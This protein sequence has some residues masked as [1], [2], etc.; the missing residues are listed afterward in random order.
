MNNSRI[1]RRNRKKRVLKRVLMFLVIVLLSV[2][3]YGGYVFYQTFQ[4]AN[5][6]YT[7]ID[8]GEKS[9]LR[10]K[11]IEI[12][13][14]PFSVLI[15]GVEDYSTGGEN[16]RTDTLI[17]AT[18]N[19]KD[20]TMK[21]L[22]IPRDTLVTIPDRNEETKI[23]HAHSYGGKDLTIETVEYFLDV[24]IDYFATVNFEGFKNIINIVDGVTVDVPFDFY[25]T[26]DETGKRL[27]FYEGKMELDGEKA[28]AYA[29]MRK[30]DPR[31]D[32]GRND[33]QRQI[34][35][36]VID[37]IL[38]PRNVFKVDEIAGEL[39]SNVE[40]NVRMAQGLGLAQQFANFKSNDIETIN[41]EGEDS[42]IG[43]VYYFVPYD[44]SIQE[45]RSSIRSHLEIQPAEDDL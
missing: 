38:S 32:F 11:K 1:K 39:G 18:I 22:S 7:E 15:M 8:R 33:R 27:N 14:D 31:G 19:P 2:V 25:E 26:S 28:L 12:G 44:E 20:K 5:S 9:N 10:D 35:A 45:V 16:G 41:I 6:A 42:Y 36:A 30:Q 4:A 3:A 29:R 43:G 37:K 24:P 21:M 40:T 17:V 23:N 34:M 13:K